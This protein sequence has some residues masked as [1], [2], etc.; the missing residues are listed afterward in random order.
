[1]NKLTRTI[2]ENN[3]PAVFTGNDLRQ[4][5]PDDHIRHCQISRA[6]ASGDIMRIRRGFYTLNKIF[7]KGVINE[8]LLANMLV[9]DS[10]ISFETALWDAGWIPEF[11]FEI[12]SVS[13]RRSFE[14]E[15]PFAVFSYT[16]IRQKNMFSGTYT[17]GIGDHAVP[18]AKPLKALADYVYSFGYNWTDLK[19]LEY[20]LRIDIEN[21]KTLTAGDFDE[22]QGN[23][24]AANVEN[25]LDGIRRELKL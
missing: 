24:D 15:T 7:R 19:P 3:L 8:H 14:I 25:F 5:E 22:I 9:P 13:M 2:L 23:Y 4:L 6:V 17:M 18:E 21:L 20:S 11:V 16:R 10:Y 12:A 1:L